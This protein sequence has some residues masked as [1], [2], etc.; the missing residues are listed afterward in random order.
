[1]HRNYNW[2]N[3]VF[4]NR[5]GESINLAVNLVADV[6]HTFCLRVSPPEPLAANVSFIVEGLDYD[7][8]SIV[9]IV[10]EA[11]CGYGDFGG[12]RGKWVRRML[13]T[14]QILWKPGMGK[15]TFGL[16]HTVFQL[17]RMAL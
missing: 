12:L 2:S 15:D 17:I 8:S 7:A 6:L 4:R 1:M 13:S 9:L 11:S 16:Q 14:G 5:C 3:P 10:D